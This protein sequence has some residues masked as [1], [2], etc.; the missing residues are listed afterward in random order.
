MVQVSRRMSG[1]KENEMDPLDLIRRFR[2]H[3]IRGEGEEFLHHHGM[4]LQELTQVR[5]TQ[6]GED[7][8]RLS[9]AYKGCVTFEQ[10]RKLASNFLD[11]GLLCGEGVLD[12]LHPGAGFQVLSLEPVNN[13]QNFKLCVYGYDMEMEVSRERAVEYVLAAFNTIFGN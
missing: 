1:N 10:K 2:E 9:R 3:D 8:E 13:G 6:M 12:D 5:N 4:T 11:K 7:F